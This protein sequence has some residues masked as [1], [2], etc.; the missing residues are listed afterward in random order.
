MIICATKPID[1]VVLVFAGF[2]LLM[3]SLSI[4]FLIRL[5]YKYYKAETAPDPIAPETHEAYKDYIFKVTVVT[6]NDGTVRYFPVV[7]RPGESK[8]EESIVS[9]DPDWYD[10][11][12]VWHLLTSHFTDGQYS[13]STKNRA[14]AELN[15][16]KLELIKQWERNT[17]NIV[18]IVTT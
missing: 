6:L 7:R 10:G 14:L 18:E 3:A 2:F 8:Y 11:T 16:Y 5:F 4:G 13:F 1:P 15:R 12:R 9:V 17:K